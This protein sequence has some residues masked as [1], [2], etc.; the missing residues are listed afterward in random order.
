[1]QELSRKTVSLLQDKQLAFEGPLH[2]KQ[3]A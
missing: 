2:V 3:L 1:M